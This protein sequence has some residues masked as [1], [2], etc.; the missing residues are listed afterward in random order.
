[1]FEYILFDLVMVILH[2]AQIFDIF[3]RNPIQSLH[4]QR[5]GGH[6]PMRDLNSALGDALAGFNNFDND[7]NDVSDSNLIIDDN[8]A[9]RSH[10]TA[11]FEEVAAA[12]PIKLKLKMFGKTSPGKLLL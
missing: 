9:A 6:A 7:Q 11:H 3:F 12:G 4:R 5:V 8:P 2:L 10:Q 1:M